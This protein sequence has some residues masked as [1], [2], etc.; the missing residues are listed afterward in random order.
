MQYNISLVAQVQPFG[1]KTVGKSLIGKIFRK[2]SPWSCQDG[3]STWN[4]KIL[5]H[6]LVIIITSHIIGNPN[7]LITIKVQ[8]IS[9]AVDTVMSASITKL[10]SS[11]RSNSQTDLGH[12]SV[13]PILHIILQFY[14]QYHMLSPPTEEYFEQMC[15]LCCKVTICRQQ[16]P[17]HHFLSDKQLDIVT[18][19]YK[20][21]LMPKQ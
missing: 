1:L 2:K 3:I 7:T 13:Q 6:F 10:E 12:C 5:P 20:T 16:H 18:T 4:H 17:K 15:F 9:H 8:F 21:T 14:L 19:G 11:E